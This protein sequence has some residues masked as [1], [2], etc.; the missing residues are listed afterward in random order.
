MV[1][2]AVVAALVFGA[3]GSAAGSM[4]GWSA[5]SP[6]DVGAL[7]S[8]VGV[9]AGEPVRR[10][11]EPDGPVFGVRSREVVGMPVAPGW[12]AATTPSRLAAAGW[13][14]GPVDL[15]GIYI[16]VSDGPPLKG[17]QVEFVARKGGTEI[18]VSIISTPDE[19][20]HGMVMVQRAQPR[21]VWAPTRSSQSPD[22]S[23][24]M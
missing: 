20:A 9:T 12:D 2:V 19:T 15:H 17:E 18:M 21:P 11:V 22:S 5:A 23:S 1:F 6:P 16:W 13:K 3:L 10:D 8:L 14:V 7:G 4:V 24:P